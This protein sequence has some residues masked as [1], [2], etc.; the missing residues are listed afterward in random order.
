MAKNDYHVLVYQIL[1]YLYQCLKKSNKPEKELLLNDSP[2]LNIDKEYWLYI[3]NNLYDEEYITGLT[4]VNVDGLD[5][6]LPV[7][8]EKSRITPKG[9]EYLNNNSAMAQ[10]KKVFNVTKDLLPLIL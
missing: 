7:M 1:A 9:I 10:V 3:I 6:K 5:Y 8:L 4:L 2:L